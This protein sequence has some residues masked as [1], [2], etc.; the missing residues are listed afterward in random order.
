LTGKEAGHSIFL[1]T[2]NIEQPTTNIQWKESLTLT[3]SH[4]MGEGTA[5]GRLL[6]SRVQKQ[7]LSQAASTFLKFVKLIIARGMGMVGG[8]DF[9]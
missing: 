1:G 4:R 8:N 5:I 6:L 7:I 9:C 3:L 2:S